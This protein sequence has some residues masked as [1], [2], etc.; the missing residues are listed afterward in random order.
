MCCVCV[1]VN[2]ETLGYELLTG[3]NKLLTE[4]TPSGLLPVILQAV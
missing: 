2:P 3:Q 4:V 1:V